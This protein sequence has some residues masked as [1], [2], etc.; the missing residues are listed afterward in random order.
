MPGS[1]KKTSNGKCSIL[2]MPNKCMMNN[3]RVAR[4]LCNK[5]GLYIL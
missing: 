2:K 3:F 4:A 5:I 1:K